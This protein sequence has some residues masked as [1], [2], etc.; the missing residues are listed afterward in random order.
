M[1]KTLRTWTV[2]L[3]LAAVASILA[4]PAVAAPAPDRFPAGAVGA[5]SLFD[6]LV[7]AFTGWLDGWIDES[8]VQHI[9]GRGGHSMDP[10]GAKR[11]APSDE[12]TTTS[13]GGHSM[14]PDG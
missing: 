14:D 5:S 1:R 6:D 9:A 8:P 10:D 13:E 2:I 4:M 11:P 12:G 3:V 7:A